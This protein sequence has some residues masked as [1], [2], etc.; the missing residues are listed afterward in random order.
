MFV[1]Y[2]G[3]PDEQGATDAN[4]VVLPASKR[5]FETIMWILT[6]VLVLSS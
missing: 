1:G 4:P 3:K 5:A 6:C 2:E